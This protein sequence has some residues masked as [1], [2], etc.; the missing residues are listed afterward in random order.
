MNQAN[1]AFTE[2]KEAEWNQNR[3]QFWFV[4]FAV[5]KPVAVMSYSMKLGWFDCNQK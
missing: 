1:L 2:D 3:T 5:Y 4:S